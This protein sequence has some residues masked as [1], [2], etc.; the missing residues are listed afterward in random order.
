MV[1]N[2]FFGTISIEPLFF[3]PFLRAL[4]TFQGTT[5]N[6]AKNGTEVLRLEYA[7]YPDMALA[8]L[9]K[10]A[11]NSIEKYNLSRVSVH[12]SISC[13][14][15]NEAGVIVSVSCKHRAASFQ[16]VAEIME[17]LKAKVP[18]WKKEIYENGEKWIEN[19][20]GCAAA[21]N[22]SK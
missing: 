9:S 2:L 3:H 18:I 6:H 22:S 19:C 15:P 1:R 10:I 4:C 7:C 20:V 16:A 12:H 11:K 21:K 14:P 5:R 13:V 8:Q 17:E